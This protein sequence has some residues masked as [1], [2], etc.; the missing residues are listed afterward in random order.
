MDD[1]ISLA[2][3]R[4]AAERLEASRQQ[5]GTDHDEVI[6]L[7][8][9]ADKNGIPKTKIAEAIGVNHETVARWCKDDEA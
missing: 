6:R 8:R 3:L 5:V 7:V 4:L 9:L 1:A 2:R